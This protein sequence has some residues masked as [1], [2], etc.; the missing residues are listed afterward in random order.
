MN[1]TALAVASVESIAQS[2]LSLRG[3]TV[4]LDSDLARLYEVETK[5]FNR[6]V[7]RNLSRFPPDFMFQLTPEEFQNLRCQFGTSNQRGGRR[8]LP[9]AFT[10]HGAVMAATILNSPRAVE[11]SV[12]V[13][14]A[15]VGL[16]RM[17]AT[18]A[19]LSEKVIEIEGRLDGHDHE[20]GAL[21]DAI[22]QLLA[23]PESP[24]ERIGF[25]TEET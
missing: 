3:L 7:K 9:H 13:V 24:Q 22:R 1:D 23:P 11:V 6:A 12:Y 14:R 8:Y 19:E 5:T 15:F 16:K 25:R 4:I 18:H 20:I 21:I 17:L 10:E 2:I